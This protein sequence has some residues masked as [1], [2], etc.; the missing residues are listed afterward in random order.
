MVKVASIVL[1]AGVGSR[2]K[3]AKNKV[4]HELSGCPMAYWPIKNAIDCTKEKPVVVVNHQAELVEDLLRSY[5]QDRIKFVKQKALDG[6]A[7]AVKA[8][9][10]HIEPDC[11][12]IFVLCGDTPLLKKESIERLITIQ[13]R[14]HIPIALISTKTEHPTGYGRIVRNNN[15]QITR[16]VEETEASNLE[17]EI[18]EI[19][20][21]IYVFDAEFL[22]K[23]ID[24]ITNNNSK[25]EYY[26]TDL[27]GLYCS[28]AARNG[29][30]E[31]IEV[32]FAET[33]GVNDRSQ[34]A[35]AQRAMNQRILEAWML[36]GVTIADPA[37]T[38]IEMDVRIASDVVIYPG[39]HLRGNTQIGE[40]CIIENGSILSDTVVEKNTHIL[41]YSSCEG[42]H[43]G[44]SC[45]V[46]PFARLRP[47]TRLD[48]KVKIGNF[49]EVKNSHIK[50]NSKANHLAYIGDAQVGESCNIGAGAITCNYDG[51]DKH[52]TVIGDNAFI[53]SNA[54]LIAPLSIGDGAYIAGGSAINKEVPKETLA[55]GRAFQVN[56]NRK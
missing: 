19:N 49:V 47:G 21:G 9:L 29:P 10:S 12:S 22:R 8:A 52:P 50:K 33:I 36:Q 27:I 53:G 17:K 20:T 41:P 39:V 43:I 48:T 14:S 56:K 51:K 46:G 5:F 15:Q 3:S 31:N 45:H 42:A 25:N 23:N 1:C 26:L 6:T 13:K 32:P 35:L 55:I 2:F 16:I 38:Y 30:V 28:E 40:G 54:T 24:K 18:Q 44:E 34:L 11:E 4:L 7:G 37:T